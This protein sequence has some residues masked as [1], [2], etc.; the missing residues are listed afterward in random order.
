MGE[1]VPMNRERVGRGARLAPLGAGQ[2]GHSA[3]QAGGGAAGQPERVV[4]AD[5][6][7]EAEAVRAVLL[8]LA[9]GDVLGAAERG[10][11]AVGL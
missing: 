8:G 9:R 3:E 6:P 5:P 7:G 4:A 11:A 10:G 2:G 1:A